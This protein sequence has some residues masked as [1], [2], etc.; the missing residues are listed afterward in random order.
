MYLLLLFYRLLK[1]GL[2]VIIMSQFVFLHMSLFVGNC[3]TVIH[4]YTDDAPGVFTITLTVS[5]KIDSKTVSR[6]ITLQRR[7]GD[8]ALMT[9][10]VSVVKNVSTS[11]TLD[12]GSL[13]TDTCFLLD[14]DD[15]ETG[16]L[17]N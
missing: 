9:D 16:E 5:N 15:L 12:F 3:S 14:F 13:G 8:I 6:T 4:N 17:V 7:V 2:K 1:F 11:W 10:F